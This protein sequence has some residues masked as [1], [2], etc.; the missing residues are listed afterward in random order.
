METPQDKVFRTLQYAYWADS[1]EEISNAKNQCLEFIKNGEYVFYEYGVL[2]NRLIDLIDNGIIDG[3]K[4]EIKRLVIEG[5]KKAI[6]NSTFDLDALN[7]IEIKDL[8]AHD[9]ELNSIIERKIKDIKRQQKQNEI[10]DFFTALNEDYSD[11][12]RKFSWFNLFQYLSPEEIFSRAQNFNIKT[13]RNFGSY[14]DPIVSYGNTRE[15]LSYQKKF[16]ELKQLFINQNKN[17]LSNLRRYHNS[18]IIT[19]IEQ[20]QQLTKFR[21]NSIL[22]FKFKG[23]RIRKPR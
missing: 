23:C 1:D 6:A 12:K 2:Y 5:C 10:E 18:V 17:A 19:R 3:N 4:E 20:I 11:F 8:K 9:E 15:Y 22:S 7:Y 14:L 21:I 13:L 16:D